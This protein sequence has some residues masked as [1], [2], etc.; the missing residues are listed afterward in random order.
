MSASM[1]DDTVGG[2]TDQLRRCAAYVRTFGADVAKHRHFSTSLNADDSV[3]LRSGRDDMAELFPQLYAPV[4]KPL[5]AA[6][7]ECWIHDVDRLGDPRRISSEFEQTE[8]IEEHW[9]T[10][11][12]RTMGPDA[13]V[14]LTAP[15]VLDDRLFWWWVIRSVTRPLLRIDR[16]RFDIRTLFPLLHDPVCVTNLRRLIPESAKRRISSLT[17]ERDTGCLIQRTPYLI[18]L[19]WFAPKQEL[20]ELFE[21]AV[22]HARLGRQFRTQF[23]PWIEQDAHG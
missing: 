11:F 7:S 20:L 2:N 10:T 19:I 5:F 8:A 15:G 18:E 23:A 1:S 6:A 13:C 21:S 14:D 3:N 17:R 12:M 4:L 22:A 9:R 16:A